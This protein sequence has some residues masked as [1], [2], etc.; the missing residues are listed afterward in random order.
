MLR[1]HE[2]VFIKNATL[3]YGRIHSNVSLG[4]LKT[5][6]GEK[7]GVV[8]KGERDININSKIVGNKDE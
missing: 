3:S 7:V 2:I 6:K 5:R 4:T 8:G 1:G